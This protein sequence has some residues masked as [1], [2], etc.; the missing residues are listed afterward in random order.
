M[1]WW[2][3]IQWKGWKL[4]G[5]FMPES[6]RR[7]IGWFWM[8]HTHTK[9]IIGVFVVVFRNGEVL[10]VNKKGVNSGWNIPGGGKDYNRTLEAQARRELYQE[11]GLRVGGLKLVMNSVDEVHRDF[12]VVFLGT[13]LHGQI[14]IHDRDEIILAQFFPVGEARKLLDE[15]HLVFLNHA[16]AVWSEILLKDKV[17]V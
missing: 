9:Y 2:D 14:E 8:Y 7:K 1:G 16:L 3:K 11:T 5:F 15:E 6:W 10:L 4:L 12:H 17:T 13:E